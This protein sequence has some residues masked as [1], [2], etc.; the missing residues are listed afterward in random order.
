MTKQELINTVEVT[1]PSNEMLPVDVFREWFENIL[2]PQLWR[3][4]GGGNSGSILPILYGTQ[5]PNTNT[6][7]DPFEVGYFY[8]QT[9]DGTDGGEFIAFFQYNGDEWVLIANISGSEF[10]TYTP[11]SKTEPQKKIARTNIGLDFDE[12]NI[13]PLDYYLNEINP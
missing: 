13:N 9:D 8:Q 5:N 2:I 10:V 11:Q 7:S 3:E 4:P 6:P 1:F 12:G